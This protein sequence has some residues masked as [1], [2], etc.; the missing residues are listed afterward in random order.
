M[1][2]SLFVF[3]GV[4]PI[5][6][7]ILSPTL[8]LL[9]GCLCF[10]LPLCFL[11]LVQCHALCS[12]L[13]AAKTYPYLAGDFSLCDDWRD[14]GV[15]RRQIKKSTLTKKT[16]FG[17]FFFALLNFLASLFADENWV[18]MKKQIFDG[19]ASLPLYLAGERKKRRE[20]YTYI[21]R[22]LEV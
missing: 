18:M 10:C 3:F 19:D 2:V 17:L 21:S 22:S 20:S 12:F 4:W 13:G 1:F 6:G 14:N 8:E 9:A 5:N 16:N 7:A 11:G 15:E